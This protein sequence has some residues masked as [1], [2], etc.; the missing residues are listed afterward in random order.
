MQELFTRKDPFHLFATTAS[1]ITRIVGRGPD[2]P[3][4]DDTC[5]RL[6]DEWWA[7]CTNCWEYD[8]VSRPT[9]SCIIQTITEIVRFSPVAMPPVTYLSLQMKQSQASVPN[10]GIEF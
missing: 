2:C 9:M 3:S 5:A 7:I 8:P 1:I 4:M 6:T 10:G